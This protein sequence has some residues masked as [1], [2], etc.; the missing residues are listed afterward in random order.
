MRGKTS[1]S[2][3][4]VSEALFYRTQNYNKRGSNCLYFKTYSSDSYQHK[5]ENYYRKHKTFKKV[6]LYAVLTALV[7]WRHALAEQKQQIKNAKITIH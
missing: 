2:S 7:I 1:L 4:T 6:L 5:C 3:Q